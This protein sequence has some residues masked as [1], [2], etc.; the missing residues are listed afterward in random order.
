MKRICAWCK[1]ELGEKEGEKVLS[2]GICPE[3][4][5]WAREETRIYK[6]QVQT[7]ARIR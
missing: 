5:K 6:E 4:L 3:C 1:A 2:H 7:V